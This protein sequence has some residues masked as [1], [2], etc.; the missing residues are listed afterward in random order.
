MKVVPQENLLNDIR[1]AIGQ[2]KKL[3]DSNK[4]Q[5][6]SLIKSIQK[7]KLSIKAGEHTTSKMQTA[8]VNASFVLMV[9]A[10]MKTELQ[11]LRQ[12]LLILET[13]RAVELVKFRAMHNQLDRFGV[14]FDPERKQLADNH[15]KNGDV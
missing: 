10:Q 1:Q 11:E 12:S 3:L 4:I 14:P 8:S 5:R 15:R 13:V 9:L 7:A 2:S 6:M